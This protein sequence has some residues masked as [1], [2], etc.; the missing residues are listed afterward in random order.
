M[1]KKTQR[2]SINEILKKLKRT[3]IGKNLNGKHYTTIP[4]LRKVDSG[5]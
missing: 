3:K 5:N 2:A 1:K 4:V